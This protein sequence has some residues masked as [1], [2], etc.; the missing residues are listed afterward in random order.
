MTPISIALNRFGLGYRQGQDL[1]RDPKAW[2]KAQ[3]AAYR[4]VP[5]AL[6]ETALT[7]DQIAERIDFN[8]RARA[9]RQKIAREGG[10]DI[11]ERQKKATAVIT[12]EARKD[13]V[14][15]VARRTNAA[16]ASDTPFMERIVHFWANHFAV[17]VS[18]PDLYNLVG[19]HEFT[20]IRPHVTGRFSD[21]LRAGSLHPAMLLYLNQNSSMGPDSDRLAGR[22]AKNRKGLNEN[23][24]REI[25]ELHSLGVGGGYDQND[26]IELAKALTGWT[27][28]GTDQR[29]GGERMESGAVFADAIHEPGSRTIMGKTYSQGGADQSLR[30]LD[31]LAVHPSTAR[32]LATKLSR[33]FAGDNP[34]PAMIARLEKRYRETGGDLGKVYEAIV[35][36]PEAWVEAPVKVRQPY[37][38]TIAILRGAGDQ[39]TG[40]VPLV[41]LFKNLGQDVWGPSSPAGWDDLGASW[42]GPDALMRR[43]SAA[44]LIAEKTRLTD[45]R[46]LAQAMFPGSLSANTEAFLKG[47]ESNQMALALLAA[48]P[49]MLRR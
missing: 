36:S 18:R 23:L 24:A 29:Y 48:S 26:V 12:R 44:E 47:A 46:A 19:P 35:D 34:P 5:E 42:L 13:Y 22:R 25:L 28:A 7:A 38:W 8:S 39:V 33:H 16:V 9:D 20:A 11:A 3:I 30:I 17:S 4:P 6:S 10:D 1:P 14:R 45:V 32:H 40:R 49:E 43:V 27:A 21:L 41:P 37:E 31:D 2:L 15:D